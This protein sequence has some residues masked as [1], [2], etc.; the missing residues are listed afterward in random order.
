MEVVR[1]RNTD[2]QTDRQTEHGRY[3]KEG[4]KRRKK[5]DVHV[6]KEQDRKRK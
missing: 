1:G 4:S 6:K 2:R 3:S 5:K